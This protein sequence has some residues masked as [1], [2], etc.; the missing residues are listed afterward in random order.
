M[1]LVSEIYSSHWRLDFYH[2]D[3]LLNSVITEL[4]ISLFSQQIT[5]LKIYI[6]DSLSAPYAGLI[7]SFAF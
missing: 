2:L 1:K 6:V 4:K 5:R 7:I 3:E